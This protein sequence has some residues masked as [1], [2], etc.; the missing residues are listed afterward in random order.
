MNN[1]NI[2][3]MQIKKKNDLLGLSK[4]EAN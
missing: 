3:I 1:L 4:F 2:I